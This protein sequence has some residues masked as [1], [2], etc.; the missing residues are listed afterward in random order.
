MCQGSLNVFIKS[1]PPMAVLVTRK[2]N[3]IVQ[4][5]N[6]GFINKTWDVHNE[7]KV[8]LNQNLATKSM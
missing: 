6:S 8:E 3:S 1:C 5:T 2:D 7:S 4:I